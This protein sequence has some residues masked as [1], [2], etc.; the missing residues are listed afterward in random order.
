MLY[1]RPESLTGDKKF[2]AMFSK[3]FSWKNTIG[4]QL[5]EMRYM[6]LFIGKY[7]DLLLGRVLH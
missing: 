3:E 4:M 1:G 6:Q 7:A 2:R 5:F